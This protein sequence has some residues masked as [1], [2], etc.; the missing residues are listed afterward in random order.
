MN[1]TL[2]TL[3]RRRARALF[4]DDT[5]AATAEYAITTMAAVAFAGDLLQRRQVGDDE[6]HPERHGLVGLE[7]RDEPRRSLVD[8]RDDEDVELRVVL[9]HLV[10]RDATGEVDRVARLA[11][12]GVLLEQLA[13]LAVAD[14][15]RGGVDASTAHRVADGWT[16]GFPELEPDGAERVAAARVSSSAPWRPAG[17]MPSSK[18]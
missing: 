2:P 14:D 13:T 1:D 3:D 4:G 11:L 7:R 16:Y 17:C 5:G 15:E 9:R 10:V 6:R 18:R 12:P 8:A